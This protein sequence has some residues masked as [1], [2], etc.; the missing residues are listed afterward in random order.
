MGCNC[1]KK[2][3]NGT[4]NHFSTEQQ[5]RIARERGVG[6]TTSAKRTDWN[7]INAQPPTTVDQK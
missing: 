2:K 5:A 7:K 1:G 4:V 3:V 6:V